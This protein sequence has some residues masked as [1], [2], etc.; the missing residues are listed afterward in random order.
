M[1][2]A[3][4]FLLLTLC[5]APVMFA[6]MTI[7]VIQT[8]RY[9]TPDRDTLY[10]AGDFNNWN[11]ADPNY[12][13]TGPVNGTLSIDLTGTNGTPLEYK[14]TRGDWDRVETD[15]NGGFLAN[16]T[17][18]F[19]NGSTLNHTIEN[20]DDT[21]VLHTCQG[22]VYWL[23][24]N[25]H[26]PQLGRDRRIWLYFPPN[27]SFSGLSYP[28]MYMHDGQNIFDKPTSFAGEWE[29]DEAMQQI[30]AQGGQQAILVGID[31]G[32]A[33]RTDEY[34]PWVNPNYGGGEGDDY[35]DFIVNTLKP[36][37]DANYRTLPDRDNTAIM[38]SSL[39]GLISHYGGLSRQDIF[40]KVGILSPSYWFSEDAYTLVRQEG[41]QYPMRFFL[42]A[43][44]ME[45]ATM[46][47]NMYRMADS[48]AVQGFDTSEVKAVVKNDGT[49]SEWFWGREYAEAYRWL[50]RPGSMTGVNEVAETKLG[51]YPS[52]T[53][54]RIYLAGDQFEGS[55]YHV[56]DFYGRT[57]IEGVISK[58][59]IAVSDL[60]EGVYLLEVSTE[61]KVSWRRFRVG[62]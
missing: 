62:F 55:A 44:G 52:P 47:P 39:G 9:F 53:L 5:V 11:P 2:K 60:P 51:I 17:A 54:E 10:L 8:P 58:Q 33:T 59:G 45:S 50:F 29:V 3:V 34:S 48:L 15:L 22:N 42:L 43:G 13:L 4:S 20:W 56:I 40:S 6:Q 28:V 35:I 46:V 25:F 26:M 23:D 30:I 27:Y 41:K 24:V 1:K 36:Y 16:R 32:G 31:N 14:F 38:G 57:V 61:K 7:Q 12:Q 21:A 49:H 37:I 18:T 19:Q